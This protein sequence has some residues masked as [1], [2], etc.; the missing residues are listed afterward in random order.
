MEWLLKRVEV[1]QEH[2]TQGHFKKSK[3]TVAAAFQAKEVGY[4]VRYDGQAKSKPFCRA[5][6]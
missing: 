2:P 3:S 4:R 6:V 1:L 5:A